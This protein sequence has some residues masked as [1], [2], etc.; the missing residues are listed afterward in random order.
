MTGW[1]AVE[2]NK[3]NERLKLRVH[4][5]VWTLTLEFSRCCLADYVKALY[6]SACPTDSTNIFPRSNQSYHCFLALSLPPSSIKH[7]VVSHFK[8]SKFSRDLTSCTCGTYLIIIE[9]KSK[10]SYTWRFWNR[11]KFSCHIHFNVKLKGF[12]CEAP[13]KEYCCWLMFR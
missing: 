1:S 12:T 5:V 11:S 8:E 6:L 13:E 9:V 7:P 4:V 2:V 10:N 3:E